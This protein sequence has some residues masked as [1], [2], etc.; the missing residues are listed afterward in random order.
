MTI[1]ISIALNGRNAT[2]ERVLAHY[3]GLRLAGVI[4]HAVGSSDDDAAMAEAAGWLYTHAPNDNLGVK[5]NAG[6]E[7]L[8]AAGAVMLIRIGSDD[9]ISAPLLSRMLEALRRGASGVIIRGS[10]VMD[11]ETGETIEL[12]RTDYALGVGS[13]VLASRGWRLYET[14]RPTAPDRMISAYIAGRGAVVV[15]STPAEPFVQMKSAGSI[16]TFER[17]KRNEI[18]RPAELPMIA[19]P[20][21]ATAPRKRKAKPAQSENT[22]AGDGENE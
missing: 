1:G 16:N 18:W 3:A 19:E 7:A 4:L 20:E 2:A 10:F 15:R 22:E 11:E 8:H 5:R 14:D 13:H 9:I 12:Y 6:L 17:I 21:P